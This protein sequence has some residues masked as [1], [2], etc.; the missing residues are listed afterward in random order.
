MRKIAT[1]L[2]AGTLLLGLAACSS[3]TDKRLTA[4]EKRVAALE[5]EKGQATP[6]AQVPKAKSAA[7]HQQQ[8]QA[9]QGQQST[10]RIIKAPIR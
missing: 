8:Q 9:Q 5:L 6:G 3:T 7:P 2:A 10:Q 1:L 4:L